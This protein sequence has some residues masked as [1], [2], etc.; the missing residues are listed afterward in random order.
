MF[1]SNHLR[2]EIV[3]ATRLTEDEFWNSSALGQSLSCLGYDGRIVTRIAYRNRRGLS[4]IYNAAIQT[5]QVHEVLLFVHDDVWLHDFFFIDRIV[6]A[7][8]TYDVIGLAGN[9]RRT[10]RQ[11]TWFSKGDTLEPNL[12]CLSGVVGHG[13]TAMEGAPKAFGVVPAECE[14]LDGFFLAARKNTLVKHGLTF[15]PRF[16]FHFYDMDFCRTARSKQ[17][18]LGTCRISAT[19]QS[20]GNFASPEWCAGRDAYLAKWGA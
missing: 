5:P 9:R 10:H 6:E 17:L 16:A 1:D 11:I 7:L 12:E 14:F 2:L 8:E 15:D 3:S 4:D 18:R 13:K 20:V 19:H